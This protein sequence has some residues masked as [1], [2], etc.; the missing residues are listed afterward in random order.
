MWCT[1]L[2]SR[3]SFCWAVFL[4]SGSDSSDPLKGATVSLGSSGSAFLPLETKSVVQF[5]LLFGTTWFV[6][7]LVFAGILVTVLAAIEIARRFSFGSPG[8]LY[9]ALAAG[10]TLA[11][12]V[13]PEQLLSLSVVPRFLAATAIAFA[14]V[15]VANL[16][17]PRWSRSGRTFSVRWSVGCWSTA[18]WWWAIGDCSW[19]WRACTAW[20]SCSARKRRPGSRWRRRQP[21]I[22]Q[23]PTCSTPQRKQTHRR[24][25]DECLA[26]FGTVIELTPPSG[27]ISLTETMRRRKLTNLCEDEVKPRGDEGRQREADGYRNGD[28]NG[29]QKTIPLDHDWV[30]D[31][32]WDARKPGE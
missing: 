29:H 18:R 25:S 32:Q 28:P 4:G 11:W 22:A 8:R 21:D 9:L 16:I 12:V 19:S 26:E 20:H 31:Q 17:C 1:S 2:T 13:S 3:T 5:A 7:A 15:F 23:G 14:P 10:L 30:D 24:P 6:N 27:R